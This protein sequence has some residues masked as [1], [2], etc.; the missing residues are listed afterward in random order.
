MKQYGFYYPPAQNDRNISP[1]ADSI[2]DY[3]MTHLSLLPGNFGP[4]NHNLKFFPLFLCGNPLTH[5]H[6]KEQLDICGKC[7]FALLLRLKR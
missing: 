1:G 5:S 7:L 3:H 6:L 4:S 2:F